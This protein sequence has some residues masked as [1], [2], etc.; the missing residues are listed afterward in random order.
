MLTL[1][2]PLK[3]SFADTIE[4]RLKQ[5]TAAYKVIYKEVSTN[6]YLIEF[7][8]VFLGDKIKEFL[9]RYQAI[10]KSQKVNPTD[11]REIG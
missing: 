5:M 8:D 1:I 6:T 11:G 10:L 4:L 9:D 7:G 2:R 3:D